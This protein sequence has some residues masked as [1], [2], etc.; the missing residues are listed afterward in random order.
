MAQLNFS[1]NSAEFSADSAVKGFC[2][3]PS[4]QNTLTAEFAENSRGNS[5][6]IQIVTRTIW[7]EL[8]VLAT[9]SIVTGMRPPSYQF[10]LRAN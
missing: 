1:A 8:G 6:K 9:P 4:I 3:F 7:K 5:L 2:F 10:S